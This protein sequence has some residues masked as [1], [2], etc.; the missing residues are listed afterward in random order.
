MSADD[1]IAVS[2][3]ERAVGEEMAGVLDVESSEVTPD[4]HFYDDLDGHSLQKM[5]LAVRIE[6]RLGV[7]LRDT[8]IGALNTLSGYV[9]LITD[10]LR[11]GG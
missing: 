7:T 3:I 11:T 9:R 2:E 1:A 4:A 5:E 10:K 6:E 8:E